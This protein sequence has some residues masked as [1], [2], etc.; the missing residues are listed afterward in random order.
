MTTDRVSETLGERSIKG[1]R[2]RTSKISRPGYIMN[3]SSVEDQDNSKSI[4]R[5]TK[6]RLV[7]DTKLVSLKTRLYDANKLDNSISF[8]KL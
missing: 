2:V 8:S 7:C 1:Q 3:M 4:L 6:N 5:A